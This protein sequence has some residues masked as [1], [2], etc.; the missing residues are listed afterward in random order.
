MTAGLR[1]TALRGTLCC[2]LLLPTLLNV[3]KS[4]AQLQSDVQTATSARFASNNALVGPL[5]GKQA[6]CMRSFE[7]SAG[8]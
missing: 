4:A 2:V 7:E 1:Q 8:R 6:Q 5:T 3:E